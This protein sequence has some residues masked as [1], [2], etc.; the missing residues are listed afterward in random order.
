MRPADKDCRR[1]FPR[2]HIHSFF[3]QPVLGKDR[4]T[5]TD[6]YTSQRMNDTFGRPCP[7]VIL[8][9]L[10]LGWHSLVA[11]T[12]FPQPNP[13]QRARR[14]RIPGLILVAI[15]SKGSQ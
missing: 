10:G 12:H 2:C 15:Y 6:E 8:R 11:M 3:R 4:D 14:V 7:W 5:S 9:G 13:A 1:R